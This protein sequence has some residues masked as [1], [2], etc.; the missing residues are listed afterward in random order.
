M[1]TLAIINQKGGCGKT[2]T[3]I[4]LAGVFAK[5]GQRTLLVDMDPQSHCAAGLAIPDDRIDLDIGD[6]MLLGESQRLDRDRLLWRISRNFDLAPSRMRLA[7]MEASR[8]GLA[9]SV[10]PERRL[11]RVLDRLEADYDVCVIDCSPSIGLLAFNAIVAADGVLIPVETSFYALRGAAKQVAS[12]RSLA[13]RLGAN[14][15]FWLLPTIHEQESPHA[16]DLLEELRREFAGKVVSQPIRRD[17]ALKEAASFGQPVLDYAP[18]STGARDYAALAGWLG[19]VLRL[20]IPP[21]ASI[22]PAEEP[23]P[24]AARPPHHPHDRRHDDHDGARRDLAVATVAAGHESELARR[25]RGMERTLALHAPMR[26]LAHAGG[27]PEH[28][29][30]RAPL[31]TPAGDDL[32]RAEDVARRASALR[33]RLAG[34]STPLVLHRRADTAPPPDAS[35]RRL[36]GARQ[37]GRRALFVQPLALGERISIVGD[38]NDWS[39]RAHVMRPNGDLGVHELTIDLPPGRH[40]YRLVVD[41][42]WTADPFN[43]RLEP[44]PFGEQ[45]SLLEITPAE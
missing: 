28:A 12:I 5:L 25:V 3:A 15:P 42:R 4:N 9:Q 20:D 39:P 11:R 31:A 30:A 40:A 22:L 24:A 6:A 43:E 37:V 35:I 13:R 7:G 16:G 27:A 26:E 34:R 17:A 45:N 1:R 33:E 21:V 19:D 10:E 23:A 2:T 44:N 38:F 8:S 18:F 14:I 36:L 41:G 29:A 32:S